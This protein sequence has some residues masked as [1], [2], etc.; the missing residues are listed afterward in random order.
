MSNGSGNSRRNFLRRAASWTGFSS[1][2]DGGVACLSKASASSFSR[3][4]FPFFRK[5]PSTDISICLIEDIESS[6]N[7]G[8]RKL[9]GPEPMTES[10]PFRSIKTS[11][12][13][14]KTPSRQPLFAESEYLSS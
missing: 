5:T 3:R 2:I 4:I 8:I 13:I 14:P 9:P 1:S 11:N 7:A 10:D 12:G 6:T